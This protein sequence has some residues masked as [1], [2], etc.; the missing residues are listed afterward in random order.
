MNASS[1][2][3]YI[4][5]V[6][7]GRYRVTER[8]AEGGMGVVYKGER[9]ELGRPVAIKFLL[10]P[11]TDDPQFTARFMR[12]AKTMSQLSHPNCVSVID[13]GVEDVPYIVMDFV[14]GK[15]LR[16]ILDEGPLHVGR[17]LN[18][19]KQ[20]LASLAHAHNQGVVHRDIK[21]DN[22]MLSEA[23]GMGDHVRIFDFG[24]AKLLDAGPE[25]NFTATN[26]AMGTP[27]Y[28]APEQ[29]QGNPVDARSDLYASGVVLFELLADCKPFYDEN[30]FRVMQMHRDK[31][32]PTLAVASGGKAFSTEL[33]AVVA[34]ALAKEPDERFQSAK[35]FVDALLAVP[36]G[37]ISSGITAQDVP[38]VLVTTATA[39]LRRSAMTATAL[40]AVV[41][42][43]A[44]IVWL[45]VGIERHN[46]APSLVTLNDTPKKDKPGFKLPSFPFMT[47][48]EQPQG[49]NADGQKKT[50]LAGL[51][52]L[53]E[54]CMAE[55][56]SAADSDPE[57]I[58]EGEPLDSQS[59]A[60]VRE[61]LAAGKADE[62]I[63]ALRTLRR[64]SPNSALY[65][66]MLG[67][68]FF[69]K[70]WFKDSMDLYREAI[71]LNPGLRRK[72]TLNENL[73][74][75]L[76]AEKSHSKAR[77]FILRHIGRPALPYL[78]RAAQNDPNRV[79]R[80]R[81]SSIAKSLSSRR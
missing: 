4:G 19:V 43:L 48:T 2:D 38:T 21:P 6:L 33:E 53:R 79:I 8:L 68:A 25:A 81:A 59:L 12:E 18:I 61:L 57:L 46:L 51:F 70:A 9:V 76:G 75:M 71:R 37:Q 41:G 58:E 22:M 36:E 7:G 24:L 34:R 30:P 66:Y 45:I 17:A 44:L 20:L 64:N 69:E 3:A 35:E 10:Q 28:M 40:I 13:F 23:T 50:G 56:D 67:E 26:M 80:K 32:P 72:K 47:K 29:S 78:K 16:E 52:G 54:G 62:A 14:T 55:N 39:P 5:V 73:I 60:E 27:N 65:P 31:P 15:T 63:A 74:A 1:E 49:D 42:V 11:F 77:T